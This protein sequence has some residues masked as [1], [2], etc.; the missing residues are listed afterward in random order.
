MA[1]IP[2]KMAAEITVSDDSINIKGT[3][4]ATFLNPELHYKQKN[5]SVKIRIR[6]LKSVRQNEL[7]TILE[8]VETEMMLQLCRAA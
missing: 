1:E 5:E 8:A 3:G 2:W 7:R 4:S 6:H